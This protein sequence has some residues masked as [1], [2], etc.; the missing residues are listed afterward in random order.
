MRT[1]KAIIKNITGDSFNDCCI[2]ELNRSG[3]PTGTTITG[4]Y[5]HTNKAIDFKAPNGDDCVVWAG[6]T[7]EIVTDH[8]TMQL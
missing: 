6:S 5:N 8:D 3:I 2:R 4:R 7:C 1:V